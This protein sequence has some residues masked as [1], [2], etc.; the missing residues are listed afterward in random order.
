[1]GNEK[2]RVG[3]I[4]ASGYGGI[5]LV[6]LLLEHPQ[7]ELT[8]LAGHSSAG[9][10]YSDLYPHLTHRVNLTIEP[11]DLE[12]IASRCDAV[13]LG[14]PNG[15]A[16]DMAPALLAKGC[17]VLDLS[18]DYRF[19]NL[20]TYTEWYKKDRQDQATNNQ[21]VYGLPELYRDAIR[22]AQLIGCPGCYPTASLLAL[23]PLLKQGFIVPETA[24]IDAKSGTSG[25]GRE[26]KVNMLLAE[27]EGSLGAYGV[28]K[29]RHT[30][31]IEQ[32]ASDL[33]GTELRVQFTPHLIPMVR[34]ILATVYAT[35]RDPGLVRDDLITIYS[36][37]YRASPFVKI[38]PHGVY[39]QTK[40]AW[41][42]NL[43]YIGIEVDPRTGRVIVLSAIDNLVKGQAGQAVQCL[44]L[45]MGWEESLGLPQLAFYP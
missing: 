2:A 38:L 8:Y 31:E 28:A 33:A 26:A 41:G 18:A 16:C 39:P 1:M 11:I 45:M 42:T 20:N 34:G 40:W 6:R 29:H 32:I 21:A 27:A 4:G 10:P 30:P 24:I 36:A 22:D 23:S 25:G 3:I 15:L 37:F 5:Q 19:R 9:K 14:L 13:F 43:C 12:A 44:N 35:L 7:V 17:K